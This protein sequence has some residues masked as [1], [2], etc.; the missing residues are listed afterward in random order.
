MSTLLGVLGAGLVDPAAPLLRADDL[1]VLRGDGC[2]ESVR[3][4]APGELDDLAEH[5]DR[6]ASSAAALELPATDRGAWQDLVDTLVGAW[7]RPGEAVL[8]LV[9]T[10]GLGEGAQPTA[11]A[12]LLPISAE[13]LRQRREGIR[14]LTLSR[15]LVADATVE[16]P[17]LLGG[18]KAISYA[19]NMAALRY[20]HANAADDVVFVSAD[21]QLLEAPTAT[22]VWLRDGVLRTPPPAPLGILDGVTVRR[23][24]Y[25]A[26]EHGFGTEICRGTVE[27]LHAAD[28]VWLVSSVRLAAAVTVLDGKALPVDRAA[29]ARVQ[30]ACGA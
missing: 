21:G 19:V 17:W 3:L 2:F 18:V 22:V 24:F 14:V 11:F 12:L 27:D 16:A 7:D 4:R 9:V 1:G 6:L 5:L 28:G 10:R 23:L 20:A 8:R 29:G 13:Q 26:A 25:R 15:G 30:A